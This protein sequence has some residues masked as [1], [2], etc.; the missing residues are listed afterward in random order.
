MRRI[1]GRRSRCRLP[2]PADVLDPKVFKAYDVRGI[3]PAELDEAGA[4]AIG[5]AYVEQFEPKRIA[6]GRDM[7]LSSPAMQQAVMRGAADAGAEVLDLGLVGTEMVYFAVGSLGL[8]GGI[9]VTASHNPKQYTGL[10]IVRRGALPV[11]GEQR[12]PRCARPDR[13]RQLARDRPRRGA[14][15]RHLARVRR[16]G[17]LLRRRRGHPAA[18][19]RDRRGER[20]GRRDAA[21]GARAAAGRSRA[22]LLRARR[23]VPEPRAEPAAAREP[24]VHRPQDA[25]GGR[26]PR[27]R[28]RRRRRPLLLRRRH[29]RVRAGRLR[30]PRCSPRSCSRRSRARRS[31]TT[32]ARAGRCPRRSSARAACRS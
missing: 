1:E 22:L 11:G 19:G 28:V 6:V 30:R 24:R 29:R 27:R 7:R 26:R 18:E 25:R 17:A 9:M 16:P 32:C 31:S 4:D 20:D 15:A 3:Y 23:L 14:G 12:P 13:G 5:R 21:A 2:A 10:K 8:D